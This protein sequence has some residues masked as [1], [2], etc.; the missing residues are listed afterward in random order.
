V[1]LSLI[2]KFIVLSVILGLTVNFLSACYS[3]QST[4][5]VPGSNPIVSKIDPVP[6]VTNS[7]PQAS[8]FSK[9]IDNHEKYHFSLVQP[10][11]IRLTQ[12]QDG[13]YALT[14]MTTIQ[15]AQLYKSSQGR[16]SI[17][18]TITKDYKWVVVANYNYLVNFNTLVIEAM[19]DIAASI[20]WLYSNNN[21]LISLSEK[22]KI[23]TK[24]AI[25]PLLKAK[26]FKYSDGNKM[27]EIL[28]KYYKKNK[29]KVSEPSDKIYFTRT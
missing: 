17:I 3:N 7:V 25:Q 24:L 6:I 1:K 4:N 28:K 21:D 11:D 2:F 15:A 16:I 5:Q 29:I 18:A 26:D 10:E 22:N 13:T 8:P 20:D 23:S 12:I 14:I 9:M 19:Q 27:V